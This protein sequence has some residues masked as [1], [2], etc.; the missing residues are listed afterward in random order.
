VSQFVCGKLATDNKGET[1]NSR[2]V[3]YLAAIRQATGLAWAYVPT[4]GG[5]SALVAPLADGWTVR[6][7]AQAE[8]PTLGETV[9]VEL[10]ADGDTDGSAYDDAT[11]RTVAGVAW[12]MVRLYNA[13][14]LSSLADLS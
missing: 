2:Q 8:A 4:G 6:L 11:Y 13:H 10:F 5:C 1:M 9:F 7:T 3:R 14:G 12:E